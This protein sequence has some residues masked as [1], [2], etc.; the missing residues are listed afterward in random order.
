MN[1]QV[2]HLIAIEAGR[3]VPEFAALNHMDAHV[4]WSVALLE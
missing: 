4:A 1:G 2:R 3:L